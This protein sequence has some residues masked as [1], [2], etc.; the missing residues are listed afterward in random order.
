MMRRI[1]K[2]RSFMVVWASFL[3]RVRRGWVDGSLRLRGL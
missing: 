2:R 1:R 3:E